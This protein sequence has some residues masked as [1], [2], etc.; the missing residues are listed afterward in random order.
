MSLADTEQ[1]MMRV[2]R[3]ARRSRKLAAVRSSR[4]GTAMT[5]SGSTVHAEMFPSIV[6]VQVLTEDEVIVK[7]EALLT[8]NEPFQAVA[9][10]N[11]RS[12]KPCHRR[13]KPCF[14]GGEQIL[15]EMSRE[16]ALGAGDAL[17]AGQD[18]PCRY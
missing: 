7:L 4:N 8:T 16:A 15:S 12:A 18:G 17:I 1:M 13:A 10:N 2:D 9:S 6:E 5:A 3:Y 14:F 11:I